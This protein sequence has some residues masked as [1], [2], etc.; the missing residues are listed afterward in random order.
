MEEMRLT[1]EKL[2]P[3]LSVK[4]VSNDSW[5]VLG[6]DKRSYLVN[7]TSDG[8]F[9]CSCQEEESDAWPW[10]Q[11]DHIYSVQ[12]FELEQMEQEMISQNYKAFA[13][14]LL[15]EIAQLEHEIA[16]NDESADFQIRRINLW[17]EH[18][19]DKLQKQIDRKKGLLFNLMQ[20]SGKRTEQL[21]NGTIKLRKQQPEII[22]DE[23]QF[24]FSD[25]RFVRIIPEKRKPDLRAIRKHLNETG[26]LLPG[27]DVNFRPDKLTYEIADH[28]KNH[29]GNHEQHERNTSTTEHTA[30]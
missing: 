25:H 9:T 5:E 11:C 28:L 7:R 21:S 14:S 12:Q 10:S 20:H 23:S 16:L 4:P 24:D 18:Q 8:F 15:W 6:L 17:R 27:V 29:G 30:A 19:N 1:R 26:E 13:D 3:L 2:R 22:V